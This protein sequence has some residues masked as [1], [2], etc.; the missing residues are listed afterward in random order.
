LSATANAALFYVVAR[1]RFTPESVEKE[2][3]KAFS[4][5][6]FRQLRLLTE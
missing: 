2:P 1:G 5:D 3:I 6:E 4:N